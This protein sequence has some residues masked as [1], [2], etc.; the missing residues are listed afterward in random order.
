MSFQPGI[1][2][3]LAFPALSV[4]IKSQDI[5]H[6]QFFG[7][8][9][10]FFIKVSKCQLGMFSRKVKLENMLLKLNGGKYIISCESV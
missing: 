1:K 2:N 8:L 3:G 9:E 6:L 10:V 5:S 7:F 4:G